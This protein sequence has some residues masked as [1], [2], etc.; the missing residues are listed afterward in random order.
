MNS[1]AA[2][3][4]A[5]WSRA[6]VRKIVGS[7]VYIGNRTYGKV[8]RNH[9]NEKKKRQP[10]EQW[11]V[12][13]NAH[14]PIISKE[15]FDAVQQVNQEVLA[16]RTAYRACADIGDVQADLFRGKLFCAECGSPMGAGKAA[17]G[18]VHTRPVGCSMTATATATPRTASAPVTTSA[19]NGCL[20]LSPM[21]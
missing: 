9:L 7:D 20:L 10:T 1:S 6:T 5:L 8:S 21:P 2:Y 16:S 12:I 11:T 4:D 18:T 3:R 19:T 14:P 17:P 15:L 13:P